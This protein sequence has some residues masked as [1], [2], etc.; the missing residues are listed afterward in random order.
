MDHSPRRRRRPAQP[1]ANPPSLPR[2]GACVPHRRRRPDPSLPPVSARAAR[3][4]AQRRKKAPSRPGARLTLTGLV[5]GLGSRVS[6]ACAA[7]GRR[8]SSGTLTRRENGLATLVAGCIVLLLFSVGG[9]WRWASGT[10][11]TKE[12]QEAVLSLYEQG[13]QLAYSQRVTP[14]PLD[15]GALAGLQILGTPTPTPVQT[16]QPAASAQESTAAPTATPQPVYHSIGTQ[17]R[18]ELSALFGTNSELIGW[19]SISG[20]LDLP[21]V[22]RDNVFYET[23]DFYGRE[24]QAGTLFLDK[25]HRLSAL[26]QNLLIHGHNMKDGTMFGR[27]VQYETSTDYLKQHG[28]VHFDTLFEEGTYVVFAVMIAS[29]DRT[30]PYYFDYYSHATFSGEADFTRYMDSVRSRS[31]YEI[32]VDVQ[33]TDALLTLSTCLNEERLV[34]LARRLRSGETEAEMRAK[35]SSAVRK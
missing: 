3:R 18:T 2:E 30:N 19:L 1:A 16:P 6:R 24:S 22:Y 35:L 21:V 5:L 34:I 17:V 23:H 4:Q 32:A 7:A 13:V 31:L 28:I 20:V 8:L 12:T 10:Q 27:L 9:L 25:N 15:S 11:R 26:T 29:Y 14:A 33:P